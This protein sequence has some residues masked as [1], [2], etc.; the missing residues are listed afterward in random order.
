MIGQYT[1]PLRRT[2]WKGLLHLK[3]GI[4]RIPEGGRLE[5]PWHGFMVHNRSENYVFVDWD[6]EADEYHSFQL[7]DWDWRDFDGHLVAER[8]SF[9]CATTSLIYLYGYQYLTLIDPFTGQS[10]DPAAPLAPDPFVRDPDFGPPMREKVNPF[11]LVEDAYMMKKRLG[12][13]DD[14]DLD[15]EPFLQGG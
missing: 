12:E 14:D 4:T 10:A 5:F 6:Q 3:P 13:G 7:F 9:L 11:T 2:A 1:T 8:M 15:T